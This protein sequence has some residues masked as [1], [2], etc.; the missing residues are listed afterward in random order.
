M[1]ELLYSIELSHSDGNGWSLLEGGLADRILARGG[2]GRTAR[3][4]AVTRDFGQQKAGN[5]GRLLSTHWWRSRPQTRTL[6]VHQRGNPH[7]SLQ[8]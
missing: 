8:S 5:D 3:N 6:L 2:A 1:S 7:Q 4:S